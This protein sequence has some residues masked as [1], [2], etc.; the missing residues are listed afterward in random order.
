VLVV[1]AG[2]FYKDSAYEGNGADELHRIGRVGAQ[3]IDLKFGV[4]VMLAALL[5]AL[6]ASLAAADWMTVFAAILVALTCLIGFIVS[7]L[8][9]RYQL[10]FL[11]V[12]R[13]PQDASTS[14]SLGLYAYMIGTAGACVV[15]FFVALPGLLAGLRPRPAATAPTPDEVAVGA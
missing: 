9:Y 3:G 11:T 8:V 14:F 5:V 10:H 7:Y 2:I 6:A 4:G 1:F 12:Q 15:S 13:P